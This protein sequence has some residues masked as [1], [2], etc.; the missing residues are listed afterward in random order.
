MRLLALFFSAVFFTSGALAVGPVGR[1]LIFPAESD[2]SY[3]Q[4]TPL[5]E[6]S[7]KAITLCMRVA[8]AP[9]GNPEVILFTYR[10]KNA[11]ELNLW[12]LEDG[13]LNLYL[14]T[15]NFKDSVY[16][17][18]PKLGPLETHLCVTWDS[19]I[20]ATTIFMNGR[21]SL[22]KIYK[23]GHKVP[24]GGKV[25]LGQ[26]A[27][28]FLGS[29]D[30]TQSFVGEIYDVNMWDSVLAT[31]TIREFN[32]GIEVPRGNIFDW[33]TVKLKFNGKVDVVKQEL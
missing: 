32:L 13:S 33:E 21:K 18:V 23:K 9:C 4:M 17:Q 27:D 22:T 30:R 28:T 10:S 5:K 20:G 11:D 24:K 16:F 3:V 19:N 1:S 31:S 2:N 14:G 25:L 29:F 26:D 7:M 15:S 8:M 6:M 12:R